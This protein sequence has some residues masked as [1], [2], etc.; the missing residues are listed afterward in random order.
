METIVK[1]FHSS[2]DY[3][4]QINKEVSETIKQY[5]E[6]GFELFDHTVNVVYSSGLH[7]NITITIWMRK[8]T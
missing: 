5:D 7:E 2:C 6:K 1:V 3:L 8:T 4:N